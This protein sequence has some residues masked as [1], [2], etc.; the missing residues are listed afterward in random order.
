MAAGGLVA[1]A[2]TSLVALK[3]RSKRAVLEPTMASLAALGELVSTSAA[4]AG[5]DESATQRLQLA[6]EEAFLY[7]MERQEPSAEEAP[8][9]ADA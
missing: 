6:G 2:L 9:A 4:N 8:S 3:T 7:L 1:I 5:W